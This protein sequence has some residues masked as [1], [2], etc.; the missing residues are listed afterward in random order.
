MEEDT[1]HLHLH[2]LSSCL[3]TPAPSDSNESTSTLEQV[4][5]TLWQTRKTGLTPHQKSYIQSLLNLPSPQDLDPVLA[6]L[7]S[8]IRKTVHGNFT[9]NDIQKLFPV[10]LPLELQS[11]LLMLLQKYQNQWQEEASRD[12][13]QWQRTRFSHQV[14][15][16]APLLPT[17]FSTSEI[18]SATWPRQDDATC[19]V[20]HSDLAAPTP[21]VVDP[22]IPRMDPVSI[23]RDDGP[24]DNLAILPRLRSMTWTM[25]NRN[26]TPANRVAVIN[27][28]LQDY[29]KSSSRETEVKFQLS[30]DTLEAMLRSMTY[31]SEQFSNNVGPA[32]GPLLKKQRQ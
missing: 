3:S 23:Q 19:H 13:P 10:D 7:R 17:P 8:L 30:K 6:C 20:S 29:T 11:V 31:I 4:L 24:P 26:S 2:K 9:W 27:L 32:S 12:Q 25:E 18:L 16:S 14:K 22:N 15:V 1:L 5:E 21:T 28:K